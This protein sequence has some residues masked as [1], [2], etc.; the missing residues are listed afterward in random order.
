LA[1]LRQYNDWRQSIQGVWMQ[2]SVVRKRITWLLNAAAVLLVVVLVS[3][4]LGLILSEAGD[5]SGGEAVRG[6]TYVALTV[7]AIDVLTL[8]GHL[9]LAVLILLDRTDSV[10]QPVGEISDSDLKSSS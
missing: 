9:T 5:T 3:V 4:C 6:L 2:I 8:L 10:E 7:F 1:L